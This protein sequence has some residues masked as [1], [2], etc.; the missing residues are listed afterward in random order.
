MVLSLRLHA[1]LL[2]Q[3]GRR[4]SQLHH[5]SQVGWRSAA[6]PGEFRIDVDPRSRM[7][8]PDDPD[9]PPMPPDDPISHQLMNCVDCKPGAP[10]WKHAPHT[11][12]V[13]NPNWE[14]YLPRNDEGQVVLD[15]QG[16]VQ[17]ALLQSTDYQEQLETLYLSSLD[18]TFER[19]RFDTQFFGGSSIFFTADGPQ[20]HGHGLRVERVGSFAAAA[21]QSAAGAEAHDHRRRARR[22]SGQLAGLAVCRAGRLHQQHAARFQPGAADLAGRRPGAGDGAA[23][24][25]RA[26][27][28]G[29]R[30]ADGAVSARR[31]I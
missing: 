13:D 16:A 1:G 24:D 12:Y 3:A 19:F 22:R 5:R 18:V 8:D 17:M 7:F 21:G 31:S 27:A 14:E 29:Q 2:S 9:C 25:R 4:G 11:P 10:C 28:V 30:A 6:A 23:H 20:S 26:G 15:L